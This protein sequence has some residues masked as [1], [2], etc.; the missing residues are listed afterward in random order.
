[1]TKSNRPAP[2]VRKT[3]SGHS[4]LPENRTRSEIADAQRSILR[5]F[6]AAFV[7]AVAA[8]LGAVVVIIVQ[9]F[10]A[11]NA[12]EGQAA[13]LDTLTGTRDELR[14][15]QGDANVAE[16]RQRTLERELKDEQTQAADLTKRLKNAEAALAAIQEQDRNPRA[17]KAIAIHQL[18]GADPPMRAVVEVHTDGVTDLISQEDVDRIVRQ[19]ALRLQLRVERDAPELILGVDVVYKC[20]GAH[21]VAA[22]GASLETT[23]RAPEV[24]GIGPAHIPVKLWAQHDLDVAEVDSP[25]DLRDL[26]RDMIGPMFDELFDL[27]HPPA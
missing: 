4:A 16:R 26:L 22:I 13:A 1:M 25:E 11:T 17:L 12:Q 15:T 18:L 10:R 14:A 27:L 21:C 3:E 8:A 2:W 20:S 5:L 24:G 19:H 9:S 7:V 6:A 23:L